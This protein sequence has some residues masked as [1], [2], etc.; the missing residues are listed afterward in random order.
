[1]RV[2][3]GRFL[4]LKEPKE[5]LETETLGACVA[6][7]AVDREEKVFGLWVFVLPAERILAPKVGGVPTTFFASEGI[8]EFLA[9]LEEAGAKRENLSFYAAGGARFLEAPTVFDLGGLNASMIRK[10]LK[11]RGFKLAREA[12]GRP[13]PCR[14]VLNPQEASVS[15]KISGEEEEKW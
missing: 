12:C 4:I 8:D 15:V 14:M 7:A 3:K 2:E 13:F 1:M 5:I 6:L 10:L 11:D 9:A